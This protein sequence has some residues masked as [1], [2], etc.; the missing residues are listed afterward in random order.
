M[1]YNTSLF[2]VLFCKVHPQVSCCVC[3]LSCS[4]FPSLV[5]ILISFT[6]LQLKSLSLF[7][8]SRVFLPASL[9]VFCPCVS[10]F[11]LVCLE[12]F[13]WTSFA[14]YVFCTTLFPACFC[15]LFC[16]L[17]SAFMFS[18]FF[19]QSGLFGLQFSLLKLAFCM[20]PACLLC[21]LHLACVWM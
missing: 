7:L 5:I 1:N 9:F 8:L 13:V 19:G 15:V 16:F 21:V 10:R 11:L 17:P 6:C 14:F 4:C 18:V 2:P 3:F 12:F 20:L